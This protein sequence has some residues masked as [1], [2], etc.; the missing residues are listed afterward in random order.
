[1]SIVFSP[2]AMNGISGKN[3]TSEEHIIEIFCTAIDKV[4][5]RFARNDTN[6]YQHNIHSN[7]FTMFVSFANTFT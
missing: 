1:M 6:I 4:L 3:N 2:I 5:Y 7:I